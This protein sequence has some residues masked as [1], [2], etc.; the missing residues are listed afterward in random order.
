MEYGF[1]G[2][3]PGYRLTVNID[4]KSYSLGIDIISGAFE[5]IGAQVEQ[6][7]VTGNIVVV[8]P[9][10]D[11]PAENA[12]IRA[13]DRILA[14]NGESPEGWSAAPGETVIRGPRGRDL[15]P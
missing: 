10:R 5:G 6:D 3:G 15:M 13:G 7:P 8:T 14:V 4:P 1:A 9:F 2:G 11:S 12:G